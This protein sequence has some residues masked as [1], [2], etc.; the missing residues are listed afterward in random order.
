[1]ILIYSCYCMVWV[2]FLYCYNRDYRYI[3]NNIDNV[4]NIIGNFIIIIWIVIVKKWYWLFF[5]FGGRSNCLILI[6]III[7]KMI[8][9]LW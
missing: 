9:E 2:F 8:E 1:M 4:L 7:F 6:L 5:G 3:N